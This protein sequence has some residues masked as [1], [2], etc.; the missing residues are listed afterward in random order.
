V[1]NMD[2]HAEELRRRI[3]FYR[4]RLREGVNANLARI[5]LFEIGEA[6]RELAELEERD[7]RDPG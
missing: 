6:E 7:G 3:E 5:Y 1:R 4:R 2:I